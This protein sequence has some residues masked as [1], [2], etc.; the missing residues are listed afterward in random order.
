MDL[1]S[2]CLFNPFGVTF[3]SVNPRYN[4]GLLMFYPSR[5]F[6]FSSLA[7]RTLREES[8]SSSSST[9]LPACE[10][11]LRQ[12]HHSRFTSQV[13]RFVPC[14]HEILRLPSNPPL[15]NARLLRTGSSNRR[16]CEAQHGLVKRAGFIPITFPPTNLSTLQP[17]NLPTFQPFK[18]FNLPTFQPFNHSTIH[19]FFRPSQRLVRTACLF[20]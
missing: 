2:T 5:G 1:V 11:T 19:I 18:P 3:I 14:V 8:I 13:S 12:A 7:D 20:R 16:R 15:R 10:A 4:L 9:C 6:R 17:S